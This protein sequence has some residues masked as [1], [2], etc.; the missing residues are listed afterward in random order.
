LRASAQIRP[1]AT[2]LYVCTMRAEGKQPRPFPSL[3]L[4]VRRQFEDSAAQY[5]RGV[6]P[7]PSGYFGI[8]V[9]QATAHR[10]KVIGSIGPQHPWGDAITDPR[11]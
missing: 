1:L 2:A 10:D 7:K 5:L 9:Q 6:Q 4:H 8:A 11:D 3:P